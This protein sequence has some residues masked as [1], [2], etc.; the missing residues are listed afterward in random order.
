MR[1]AGGVVATLIFAVSALAMAS[2]SPQVRNVRRELIHASLHPSPLYPTRIPQKI[3]CCQAQL[4][5]HGSHFTVSFTNGSRNPV[6]VDYSRLGKRTLGRYIKF[7]H[8]QRHRVRHERV[9]GRRVVFA[10]TDVT[11][12]FGWHAQGYS[13][14]VDSH[15]TGHVKP[16]DL[17]KM[18]A[19]ARP[20]PTS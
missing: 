4:N 5:R 13:Y 20:L 1:R 11:F 12:F 8:A 17:R 16:R 15:Y 7:T 14:V 18:V 19:S 3:S 2:Q 9:G 10:R 6:L